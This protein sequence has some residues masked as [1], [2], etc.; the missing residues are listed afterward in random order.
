MAQD[1]RELE[2]FQQQNTSND[3]TNTEKVCKESVLC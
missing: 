1:V 3:I 2:T